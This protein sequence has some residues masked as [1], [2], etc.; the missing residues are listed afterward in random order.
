[1]L[2]KYEEFIELLKQ[3]I[4]VGDELYL[5]LLKK[6]IEN[7]ERYCGLFRLSNVKNKLIQNLTQSNEI[8][9]GDFLEDNLT[10]CIE[11]KGYKNLPKSLKANSQ[12]QRYMAD[13]LF[14]KNHEIY[15]IEQKIRDDHDSTKKR[16]Q[17][18]NFISKIKLIRN[19]YPNLKLNAYMWFI[20]ESMHK[21]INYYSE[22]IAKLKFSNTSLS[23]YYGGKLFIDLGDFDIW[24]N[25]VDN[26]TF[27]RAN[28]SQETIIIPDFDIS[29]EIFEA[30]KRL[31]KRELMKLLSN[32][33]IYIKVREELF[34][35]NYN[36]ERIKKF[37]NIK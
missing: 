8:K 13:Q 4:P 10:I 5:A 20:D 29:D 1:M 18:S 32:K 23:I 24:Q 21:N 16:G 15:F 33:E 6:I 28:M 7:P 9:L 17:L 30:M 35:S 19:K 37:Y 14:E 3:K 11:R 34:S 25:L 36:I 31:Q 22:E 2:I 27:Y 26:L 12:A